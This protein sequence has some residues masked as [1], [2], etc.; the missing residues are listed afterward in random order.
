MKTERD[1]R[2]YVDKLLTLSSSKWY[3]SSRRKELKI[4]TLFPAQHA[5]RYM[6]SI[7]MISF[8]LDFKSSEITYRVKVMIQQF[9]Y[10]N[11]IDSMKSRIVGQFQSSSS[12]RLSLSILRVLVLVRARFAPSKIY[13][14]VRSVQICSKIDQLST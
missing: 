3:I 2:T 5:V 12:Y 11:R 8:L 9:L 4:T 13:C 7:T 10:R 6:Y 14:S 1:F